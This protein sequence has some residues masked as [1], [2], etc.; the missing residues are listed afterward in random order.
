MGIVGIDEKGDT[1]DPT[2]IFTSVSKVV[3]SKEMIKSMQHKSNMQQSCGHGNQKPVP[4]SSGY[5]M[6]N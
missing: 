2:K 3:E 6:V 4:L 1:L 5:Q